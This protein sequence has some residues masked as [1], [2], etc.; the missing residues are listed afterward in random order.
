MALHH[1]MPFVVG[2]KTRGDPNVA[3]KKSTTDPAE[4]NNAMRAKLRLFCLHLFCQSLLLIAATSV[5]TAGDPEWQRKSSVGGDMPPPNEGTQQTCCVVADFDGDGT[6]DFAVGERTKTPSVVW[7]KFHGKGWNKHVI[8]DSPLKPEAGGVCFDVDGDGDQDLVLGQDGSGSDMWWWEN[9]CPDFAK[10]WTRRL[11]KNGGARKHHDQ[12]V[13][14]FDG[15]G[16]VELVSW[17]QGA[18]QLL[19]YEIPGDPR[20]ARIWMP[21][22]I[23][24]WEKGQ[25]MEGFPSIPMDIDLDGKLDLVGGG[26]WFKHEGGDVYTAHVIDDEKRFTQCAAGQL[27]AGGRPE[28]VFS[29]GDMDGNAMWF[30]WKGNT[31]TAH[32]LGFVV[33][34]H[35]CEIRDI[36]RDG[37]PDIFIGEMGSPGAGDNAK[38]YVWYGDGAGVFRKTIV[39]QGQGIH[40][41]QVADL[42]GDGDLDILM[43]PY[44]H[45]APRIDVLLQK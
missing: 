12:T 5:A 34:G 23:Y 29:P 42:D 6:A 24:S 35:T 39:A 16:K 18:R 17:N 31:W 36:N 44:H 25:E 38:T 14:D 19:L 4:K 11:I 40:E 13:G 30:E 20:A 41:G 9:P 45:N 2:G 15:D 21:T 32:D 28:I 3:S 7:Y 8:D 33:H 27:V 26:R 10:P 43:K 1:R 22:V 37:N